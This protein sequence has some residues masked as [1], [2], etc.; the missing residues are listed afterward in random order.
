MQAFFDSVT[1]GDERFDIVPLLRAMGTNEATI[2]DFE[3]RWT[4]DISNLSDY[5]HPENGHP[6]T[7]SIKMENLLGQ[8][9]KE[10]EVRL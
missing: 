9:F 6:Y 8:E 7:T 4:A 3:K 5:L 10:V 2:S 1:G